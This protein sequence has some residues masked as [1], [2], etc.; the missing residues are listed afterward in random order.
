MDTME[1][2]GYP[3]HT[4][5]FWGKVKHEAMEEVLGQGPE[6]QAQG[7]TQDDMNGERPSC[8]DWSCREMIPDCDEHKV[9]RNRDPDD[10]DD[11]GMDVCEKLEKIRLE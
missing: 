11:S 8:F 6:K 2:E 5:C 3:L 7:K 4:G 10:G 9:H 1:E